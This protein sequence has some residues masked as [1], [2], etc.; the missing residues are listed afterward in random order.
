MNIARG[1]WPMFR[2]WPVKDKI[3]SAEDAYD[4]AAAFLAGRNH[5][6]LYARL[7]KKATL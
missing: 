6:D 1:E 2:G 4:A 5:G 3:K 7:K